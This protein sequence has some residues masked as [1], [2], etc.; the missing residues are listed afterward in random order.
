VEALAYYDQQNYGKAL[1]IFET[2]ADTSK[3][4][5]NIGMIHATLGEHDKAVS[6][7][8]W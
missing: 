5:F 6:V 2:N 3:I 7:E 1:E 8:P 4:Y